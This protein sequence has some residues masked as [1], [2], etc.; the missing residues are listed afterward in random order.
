MGTVNKQHFNVYV[1]NVRI[2]PIFNISHS[3]CEHSRRASH[4]ATR[5]HAGGIA[6]TNQ[7]D[8]QLAPDVNLVT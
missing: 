3:G 8:R 5:P 4:A 6:L 1:L 7:A 2:S